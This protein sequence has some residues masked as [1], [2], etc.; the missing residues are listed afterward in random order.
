MKHSSHPQS[1]SL[2]PGE[3][4]G[5]RVF[6]AK[7]AAF[8]V[9]TQ[10][11]FSGGEKASPTPG[12]QRP[13]IQVQVPPGDSPHCPSSL[14]IPF[15]KKKIH[16]SKPELNPH[17]TENMQFGNGGSKTV[18][19]SHPGSLSRP[20]FSKEI[21]GGLTGALP[22]MHIKN[23]VSRASLMVYRLRLQI[24]S[25]GGPSSIPLGN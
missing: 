16:G 23:G 5:A 10:S 2:S 4:R 17:S 25:A 3:D 13:R 15:I 24:P 18:A 8:P 1:H 14:W 22:G 20:C 19:A 11:L 7:G 6:M 21:R 12:R 9:R